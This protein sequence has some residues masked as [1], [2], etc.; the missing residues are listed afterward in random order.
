MGSRILASF[1]SREGMQPEKC[2]SN[3]IIKEQMQKDIYS[4][5]KMYSVM[6]DEQHV[7]HRKHLHE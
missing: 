1:E 4:N 7:N 6:H 5:L 3:S 2:R